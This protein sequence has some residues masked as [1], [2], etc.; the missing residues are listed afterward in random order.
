MVLPLVSVVVVQTVVVVR[1]KA[2]VSRTRGMLI[3][4]QVI[5]YFVHQM[6]V[7]I[8]VRLI[9]QQRP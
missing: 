5:Q 2:I 6:D 4:Q 8:H 1:A 3:P 9:Q 7:I